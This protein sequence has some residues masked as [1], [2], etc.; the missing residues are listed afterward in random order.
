[1]ITSYL[2]VAAAGTCWPA[3]AARLRKCHPPPPA[4]WTY[5]DRDPPGSKSGWD[6]GYY[7]GSNFGLLFSTD[8]NR[9]NDLIALAWECRVCRL[10]QRERVKSHHNLVYCVTQMRPYPGYDG[11]G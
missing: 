4:P 9:A 7:V 6:V 11:H 8:M 2:N 10:L 3:T 1:M 5:D